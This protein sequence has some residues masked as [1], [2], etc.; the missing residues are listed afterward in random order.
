MYIVTPEYYKHAL[1]RIFTAIMAQNGSI[2][3]ISA[4][5]S[6]KKKKK[7]PFPTFRSSTR[8]TRERTTEEEHEN[9]RLHN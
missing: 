9:N 4:H 2:T 6:R 3:V 7:L 1:F 5:V 8:E